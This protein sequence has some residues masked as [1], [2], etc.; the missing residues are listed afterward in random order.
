MCQSH[1]CVYTNYCT[2]SDAC[3]AEELS[4]GEL[5]EAMVNCRRVLG[6]GNQLL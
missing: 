4:F 1:G 6:M 5:I 2:A 3:R